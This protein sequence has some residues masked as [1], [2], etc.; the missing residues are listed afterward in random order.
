MT[1]VKGS[2]RRT[3]ARLTRGRILDAAKIEFVENGYHGATIAA[4]ARRAEVATQTVYFVF[5][6]KVELMSAVID[7]AVLGVDETPPEASEWWMAMRETASAA[8]ALIAF[9]RGVAPLLERAAFVSV[10]LKAAS[11][12]DAEVQAVHDK[13]DQM[14]AAGYRQVIDMVAAKGPLH[15][16]LTPTTATDVLLLLCGDNTYV[17]LRHDRGWSPADIVTFLERI[18]VDSILANPTDEVAHAA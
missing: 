9:V 16:H 13:H 3:Q 4:I 17:Q 14:Q 8:D 12:G 10:V 11:L 15:A 1:D 6:T 5:H 18:V 7:S 2:V